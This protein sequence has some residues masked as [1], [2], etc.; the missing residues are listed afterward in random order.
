MAQVDQGQTS[1]LFSKKQDEQN[2]KKKKAD[3]FQE[4]VVT[5]SRIPTIA[6]NQVQPVLSYSRADIE[7]SGQTSIGEIP[8]YAAGCFD[9]HKSTVQ[10]GDFRSATV[11]LHGLPVGTTLTLLD[12]RRLENNGY[13]F[14]DLSNI[15]LAAVER[16]EICR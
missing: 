4:V 3:Q 5:G 9:L 14:F 8:E 16:I 1:G 13:G 6:G 11:Q 10:C 15:P 12:G 7:N 2:S